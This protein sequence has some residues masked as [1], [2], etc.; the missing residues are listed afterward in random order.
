M[1]FDFWLPTLSEQR[2]IVDYLDNLKAKVDALKQLQAG[3]A[4]EI[5]ALLPSVLERRSR[6]SCKNGRTAHGRRFSP[7]LARRAGL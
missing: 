1:K 5:D 6:A 4:A 2:L 7:R 3:T